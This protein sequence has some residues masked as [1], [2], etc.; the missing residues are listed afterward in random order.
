MKEDIQ[1]ANNPM[2][3]CPLS[4]LIEEMEIKMR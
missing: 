2:K 3:G 4:Y 1:M